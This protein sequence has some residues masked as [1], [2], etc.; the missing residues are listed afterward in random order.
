M[1]ETDKQW[2]EKEWAEKIASRYGIFPSTVKHIYHNLIGKIY[3]DNEYVNRKKR[4]EEFFE[5]YFAGIKE[6][7]R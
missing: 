3:R 5:L 7:R 2:N 1:A 6:G 4:T